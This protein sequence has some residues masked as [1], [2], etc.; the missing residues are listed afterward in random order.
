[1]HKHWERD[2]GAARDHLAELKE[3]FALVDWEVSEL[4]HQLREVAGRRGVGAGKVIHPLRVALT[5]QGVSPG[6]F[7]VLVLLGRDRS[8]ARLEA[9]LAYLAATPSADS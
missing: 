1:V 3:V 5:G 7:E 9:A 6:I 2:P 4:E 8:M